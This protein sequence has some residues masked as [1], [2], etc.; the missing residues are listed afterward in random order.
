MGTGG[1]VSAL[2]TQRQLRDIL[3]R[4][5]RLEKP[6]AILTNIGARVYR[7][8]NK[9]ITD[10][11]QTIVDFDA[12]TYDTASLHDNSTNNTRLTIPYAGKYSTSAAIEFA[13][14]GTGLRGIYLRINGTTYIAGH[15]TSGNATVNTTLSIE[16]KYQ[17]SV[18]D[19]IE[20]SVFQTSGGNLDLLRNT[21]YSPI[22]MIHRLP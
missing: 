17:F 10:S 13:A 12:E 9:S 4:L 15:S 6:D 19:Y 2:D 22:F 5:E 8:T 21:D 1:L 18:G 3:D 16:T 11:T 7:T 20:C 14:N